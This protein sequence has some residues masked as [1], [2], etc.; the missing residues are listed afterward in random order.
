MALRVTMMVIT[1]GFVMVQAACLFTGVGC[2]MVC[3]RCALY[4][5]GDNAAI[6]NVA[7]ADEQRRTVLNDGLGQE[8]LFC[9]T[10][11]VIVLPGSTNTLRMWPK[12][13]GHILDG[14]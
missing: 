3:T 9:C 2:T 14:V 12:S 8:L 11:L 6:Y 4:C 5:P 10:C 7:V 13:G 1:P